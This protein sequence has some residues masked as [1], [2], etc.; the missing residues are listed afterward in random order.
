MFAFSK[1]VLLTTKWWDTAQADVKHHA[2]APEVAFFAIC[3]LGGVA[4]DFW[5]HVIGC[6][7]LT[8]KWIGALLNLC[9]AEIRDFDLQSVPVRQED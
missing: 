5:C 2:H 8:L 1:W 6:A 4:Q 3:T 7:A 9:Q